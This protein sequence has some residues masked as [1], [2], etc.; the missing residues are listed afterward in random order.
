MSLSLAFPEVC[1]A[2]TA[3][4][5]LALGA[6]NVFDGPPAQMVRA[7]GLAIGATR[8]DVS[9]EFSSPPAGLD[10]TVGEDITV[11]CLAWSGGGDVVFKPHRDAVNTI[12]TAVAEQLAADRTLG[13]V[14]DTA[15]MTGGT[16]MQEQT[17]DGALV[18]CEFRIVINRF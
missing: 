6:D 12:M 13:G 3:A 16:W 10:G 2:L 5:S 8:E 14:A 1:D 18:T 17:G 4:F 9:S 15:Y 7:S 11:T